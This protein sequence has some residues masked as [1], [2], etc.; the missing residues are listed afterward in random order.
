MP[1]V[2]AA[3]WAVAA[4]ALAVRVPAVL[5]IGLVGVGGAYVL[6]LTLGDDT[7]D[8]R[9]PI[10][11]ALVFLGTEFGFWSLEPRDAR[12]EPAVL[13]RRLLLIAAGGLGAALVAGLLLVSAADISGGV[14]VVALGVLA[15]VVAVSIVA[16]LTARS[17]D[18]GST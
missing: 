11:A 17:R 5:P 2:A 9:A 16:V 4:V 13:V 7:V 3:G 10:V 15:A 1:G 12:A 18:S 14:G 8:A 6:F